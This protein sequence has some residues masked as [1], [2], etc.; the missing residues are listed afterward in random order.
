MLVSPLPSPGDDTY[1]D[2]LSESQIP[3]LANSVS[4]YLVCHVQH[5]FLQRVLP[6]PSDLETIV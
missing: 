6:L 3:P 2:D 4:L 5:K 1:E